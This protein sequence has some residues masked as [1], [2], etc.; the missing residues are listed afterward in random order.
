MTTNTTTMRT[1]KTASLVALAGALML[2]G[3]A[4]A[5]DREWIVAPYLWGADTS[6]DVLVRNDPVFSGDLDFSDLVDKLELALQL[7]VETRR[8]SFGLLFDVTYLETSD[9]LGIDATPVLPASTTVS[10]GA[11]MMMLE[12]GGFYRASGKAFGLDLLL[13]VRTIDLD[14]D[15]EIVPPT[16]LNPR[17]VDGSA[18]LVDGFLG[19]R[20]LVPL[21]DRWLLTLRGDAGA[22]DSD[23]SWNASA[24]FGYCFGENDRFN[25]LL[26]YRHFAVEYDTTD[27]GLPIEVDMSMSGPQ[28][29]FAFRF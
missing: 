14:V 8:D 26:G 4:D 2:G 27:Q 20:Y 6:L 7:H 13:G 3:P 15:V 5:E 19:L 18:S 16:P 25:V 24:L 17:T 12:V 11:D 22:G 29:A 21:G 10:T 23:L 9:A 1:D 28:L